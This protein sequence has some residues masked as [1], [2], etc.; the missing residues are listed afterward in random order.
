MPIPTAKAM[1]V[2]QQTPI[3]TATATPVQQQVPI[4]TATAMPVQQQTPIATATAVPVAQA[5]HGSAPT[6]QRQPTF[7][8][9]TRRGRRVCTYCC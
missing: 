8:R 7:A 2:Q 4:A 1:P 3:A 5:G 9:A 6:F